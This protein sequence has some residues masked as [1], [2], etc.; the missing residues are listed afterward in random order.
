MGDLTILC[1]TAGQ[2]YAEPYLRTFEHLA[3]HVSA[4][5]IIHR[6]DPPS[7]CIERVLDDALEQCSGEYVLRLDDDETLDAAAVHWLAL[8]AYREHDHWAFPRRNLW[9]DDGQ[10]IV[11]PPLWPDLQTRL[12]VKAKSGGRSLVHAGSPHGTGNIAGGAILHHKFLIRTREER[13]A[14]VTH[15]ESIQDGAGKGYAM[16]SVPE[17]YDDL[18]TRPVP[19]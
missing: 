2:P 18:R 17:R 12:S 7:G 11:N 3:A 16:F 4:E 8:G 19:A 5:L 14:L 10:Y 13:E 9:P 15:Y 6:D 1:V